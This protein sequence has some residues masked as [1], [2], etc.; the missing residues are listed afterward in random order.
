MKRIYIAGPYSA[1]NPVD[2]FNNI[3]EGLKVSARILKEGNAP[4]AP[5]LDWQFQMFEP[6]LV[7][8]D[9]YRYSMAWL[10]ASDEILVL[11]GWET[12][13]GTRAELERA[14]EL[15]IPIKFISPLER[16]PDD[17]GYDPILN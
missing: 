1:D 14:K 17:F 9:Y 8:E 7:V 5:W 2:V 13:K 6:S 16:Q 11:P 4:F 10:E 3:R 15:K 12:S